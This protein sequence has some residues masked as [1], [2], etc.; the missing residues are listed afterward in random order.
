MS[1]ERPPVHS[2]PHEPDDFEPIRKNA[3][4]FAPQMDN[5]FDLRHRVNAF[6]R[7]WWPAAW[8]AAVILAG[9]GC[10]WLALWIIAIARGEVTR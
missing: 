5:T 7:R 4:K 9:L 8:R 2:W 3:H 6:A 10:A 1:V